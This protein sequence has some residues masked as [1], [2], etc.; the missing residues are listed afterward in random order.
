MPASLVNFDLLVKRDEPLPLVCLGVYRHFSRRGNADE[1]FR[2]HL[3][4][5][6]SPSHSYFTVD[7]PNLS[8]IVS[9]PPSSFSSAASKSSSRPESGF[10]PVSEQRR[11]FITGELKPSAIVAKKKNSEFAGPFY[12]ENGF[13]YMTIYEYNPHRVQ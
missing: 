1:R 12:F 2:L 10:F 13:S 6:N 4:D 8:F 7:D 3:I 11:P 5:L 9:H